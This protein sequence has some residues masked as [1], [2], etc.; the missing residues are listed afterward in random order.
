M[1]SCLLT[2]FINSVLAF[3]WGHVS[4]QTMLACILATDLLLIFNGSETQLLEFHKY[5]N[6]LNRNIKLTIE[7]SQTAINFLDLT[8]SK[9]LLGN[10]HTTIFRKKTS[11]N[12][13]L[14]ADSFHPSYLINNIPFG[15]FQ[16]LRRLCDEE[17][18]FNIQATDMAG[19]FVSRGYKQEVVVRARNKAHDINR[20][21]LLIKK[22]RRPTNSS[23]SRPYFVTQYSTAA[24]HISRIIKNN[25]GIINSDP[26]LRQ[27]FPEPPVVSFKRAPTL[28][29]KLV[30]NFLPP[31]KSDSWLKRP[32]GCYKCMHCPH[33]SNVEQ[34]KTF[35]DFKTNKTY[36]INDFINCS[37]THVIYRLTCT[38]PGVFYVGRTKRRLRDR[39]AEHKYA[40]RTNN[41][42]YP[43]ARHFKEMHNSN[44]GLLRIIGLEQIK[45]LTRGGDRLRKLN[46]RETFWI[47]SLDAL[48]PPGLNEDIDFM[49]FL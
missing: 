32:I 47:H 48:C 40:I 28:R 12:T 30:N 19:R 15:Q 26:T 37:T 41:M 42:V 34:T 49:C 8:I 45:P 21:D 3:L 17:D 9:D 27:V 16:R 22:N 39:L 35:M 44:D 10:L 2:L 24:N 25:W 29:D 7:Y 38:C 43:I 14:R 6:T 31:P 4:L 5:L 20:N 36:K 13:L 23:Q 18:D 1:Y 11:R 33:C 46:Q